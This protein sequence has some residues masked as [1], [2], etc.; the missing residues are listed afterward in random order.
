[1][2]PAGDFISHERLSII[3]E[4]NNF[5][6]VIAADGVGLADSIYGWEGI[7]RDI[8]VEIQKL[9]RVVEE[10]ELEDL[11]KTINLIKRC[12]KPVVFAMIRTGDG[13]ETVARKLLRQNYLSPFSSTEQ[14]VE[15]I[16]HLAKYREY[17]DSIE[18][19]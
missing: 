19:K 10:K 17:L 16:A 2:D 14:A 12:G 3:I 13:K 4:D 6:A 18:K 7:P 1:M 5:D 15:V 11:A 8:N 9:R